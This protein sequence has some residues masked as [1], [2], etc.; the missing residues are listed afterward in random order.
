LAVGSVLG[1]LA[2]A[3]GSAALNKVMGGSKSQAGASGVQTVNNVSEVLIPDYLK[4]YITGDNGVLARA[5]EF[6]NKPYTPYT[7]TRVADFN[8]DQLN[9]FQGVRESLGKYLPYYEN[10]MSLNQMGGQQASQGF[11]TPATISQYMNPYQQNVTDIAKRQAVNDFQT[12][13][14]GIGDFAANAG[15]FGGDRH[16]ILESNAYQNLNQNL[17]DLQYRGLSDNYNQ[18]VSTALNAGV[19]QS[20]ALAQFAQQQ[21]NLAG[22]AQG[23]TLNDLMALQNVGGQ[24]Q[25]RDQSLADFNYQ[26]FTEEQNYP[27]NQISFLQS[28]YS[29]YLGQSS[30]GTTNTQTFNPGLSNSSAAMDVLKV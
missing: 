10:A 25:A 26:Q 21:A 30:S 20:N 11:V 19:S 1:S 23:Y 12:Q 28:I 14:N 4:S 5:N 13:L 24:Q 22:S 29:P 27:A 3:A 17:S 2:V 9:S 18:A 8:T 15:A 16:A 6:G 7:G